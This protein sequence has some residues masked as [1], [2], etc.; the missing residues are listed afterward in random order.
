M[1]TKKLK[2][3]ENP[4]NIKK[5]S[6]KKNKI[7]IASSLTK[8]KSLDTIIKAFALF[9]KKNK[10]WRLIIAGEGPEENYLKMLANK[11]EISSNIDWLG[12]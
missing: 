2:Y 10:D 9:L 3:I 8:K 6:V 11:L 12:F 5:I 1:N 4:I 7:F